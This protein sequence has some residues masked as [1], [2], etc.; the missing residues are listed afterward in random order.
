MDG[1]RSVLG[2]ALSHLSIFERVAAH[3]K[4][5]G[6]SNADFMHDHQSADAGSAEEDGGVVSRAGSWTLVLE[7]DFLL[8]PHFATLLS[9]SWAALPHSGCN[10]PAR[11]SEDTGASF[12][13]CPGGG[14]DADL[15]YLGAGSNRRGPLN[16]VNRRVFRPA[17]TV[18]PTPDIKNHILHC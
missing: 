15:V 1:S 6:S 18:R 7:D 12:D 11:S 9:H 4:G 16:W 14:A 13:A 5:G 3:N 8:P 17:Q 10:T 2:C